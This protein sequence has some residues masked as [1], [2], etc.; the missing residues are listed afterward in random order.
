MARTS[1]QRTD[2]YSFSYL[3]G[4]YLSRKQS[5]FLGVCIGVVSMLMLKLAACESHLATPP[6]GI[7]QEKNCKLL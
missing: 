3:T 4:G 1:D 2:Y 6:L 5:V 7:T